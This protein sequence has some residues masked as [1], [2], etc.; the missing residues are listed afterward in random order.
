R[1]LKVSAKMCCDVS[2]HRK[3]D[4]TF[5]SSAHTASGNRCARSREKK[6][7]PSNSPISCTCTILGCCKWA[8]AYEIQKELGHGGMG[9]VYLARQE[10][11]NRLV[12]LK[13]VL[14]SG[15]ARAEEVARFR[16]GYVDEARLR[17]RHRIALDRESYGRSLS[18]RR[19]R[20]WRRA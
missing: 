12:A 5:A 1:E 6:G 16:A 20:R 13:M 11:L 10:G 9:V 3:A 8:A 17:V 7:R 15:F 2:S 14:G 18:I 19:M 4:A